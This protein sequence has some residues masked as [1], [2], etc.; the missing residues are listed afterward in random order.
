MAVDPM[1]LIVALNAAAKAYLIIQETVKASKE[2][3]EPTEE[4]LDEADQRR[5]AAVKE[6]LQLAGYSDEEIAKMMAHV[7]QY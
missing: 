3:R 6:T 4:E 7:D 1:S 2:D 5:H